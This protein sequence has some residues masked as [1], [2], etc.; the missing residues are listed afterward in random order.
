QT[1]R[2]SPS[3]NHKQD[4]PAYS[5]E[6][7]STH[8]LKKYINRRFSQSISHPIQPAPPCHQM[9]QQNAANISLP[10]S[11]QLSM[12]RSS[13]RLNPTGPN[14]LENQTAKLKNFLPPKR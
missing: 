14:T 1:N 6:T 5:F 4:K 13:K 2:Q 10:V 12:N 3:L 8:I 9:T 7:S 11:I